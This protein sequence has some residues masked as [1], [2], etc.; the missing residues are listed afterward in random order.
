MP[1]NCPDTNDYERK[2]LA[3][4]RDMVLE[5]LGFVPLIFPPGST[6]GSRS[7]S[8]LRDDVLAL[9]GLATPLA[10]ATR[11]VSA[12]VAD[13]KGMLGMAAMATLAPG[14]QDEFLAFIN[15]ASQ[16]LYRRL[17]LDKGGVSP[18]PFYTALSDTT[19]VVDSD[20]I[21]T[22]ATGYAKAKYGQPDA[23]AYFDEAERQCKDIVARRPPNITDMVT[24]ALQIAH[25]TVLRRFAEGTSGSV[26]DSPFTDDDDMTLVD[27]Q[28]VLLS[29]LAGLKAKI[30]Q[31][32]AKSV[33]QD[34]AQYM[35]DQ[36]KRSPPNASSVVTRIVKAVQESLY[37]DYS[38]FRMERFYSWTLVDGQRYYGIASNDEVGITVPVAVSAVASSTGG[39]LPGNTTYA[40]KIS[41]NDSSDNPT[42]PS[43]FVTVTTGA[44]DTNSITITWRPSE[45]ID[46]SVT[47]GEYAVYGRT[48]G[49]VG[50]LFFAPGVAN[51][52]GTLSV[53]DDGSNA[54]STT[55]L[56]PTSSMW[57][58]RKIDPRK[59]TWAGV[60]DA[61]DNQWRPLRKGIPPELYAYPQTG[62]PTHF[63][64]RQ[65]IELWPSPIA[66]WKLRIKGDFGLDPFEED[67]DQSTIDW[68]AIFFMA[69]A[70][71]KAQYN[72]PDA[73]QAN[74]KA[75]EY[76]GRLVAGSH[77]TARYIP[78][79]HR[80]EPVAVRP[81][82]IT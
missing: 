13:M 4:L 77:E 57:S 19:S 72:M 35:D 55:H 34:Y 18:P 43:G 49:G 58:A 9:L 62:V 33:M 27:A 20:M 52:D 74:G 25:R 30:G 41:A 2:T 66:D 42:M 24:K 31:G 53:I 28:P 15:K 50:R 67:G 3:Q 5:R 44:G 36:I 51:P 14:V 38:V 59:V 80:V 21:L 39:T 22:L 47:L 65:C 69:V 46:S 70:E 8:D 75:R 29:A 79:K 63:E 56:A 78:G 71:A 76:I 10:I 11:L 45:V 81:V 17:E 61:S 26:V 82:L 73:G 64:V 23:K 6:G 40:Y 12:I 1:F 54:P 60:C 68:Q 32:D 48:N 37:R 7:L 16:A